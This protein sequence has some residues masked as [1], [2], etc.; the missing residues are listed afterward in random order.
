MV[1]LIN[2]FTVKEGGN[3]EFE[4]ILDGLTGYMSA[5]PGFL[6]HRL[7][8]SVRNRQVYVETAEWSD[9]ESHRNA[10]GGEEFR[11]HIQRLGSVATPDPDIFETVA[12]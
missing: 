11:S 5:Q 2:R 6:G 3:E 7:L 1:T 8:R 12:E 4:K 9:A 10:M